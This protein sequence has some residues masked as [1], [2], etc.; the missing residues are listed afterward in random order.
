M[1]RNINMHLPYK[2]RQDIYSKYL[3][4]I[5]RDIPTNIAVGSVANEYNLKS[6][7]IK[8]CIKEGERS[9]AKLV[10]TAVKTTG[11]ITSKDCDALWTQVILARANHKCEIYGCNKTKSIQAHHIFPRTMWALR[12]EIINGIALCIGHHFLFPTSAHKDAIGFSAWV[13]TVRDIP[14]LESKKHNRSKHDYQAIYLHLKNE[15][16]KITNGNH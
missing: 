11:K 5:Q 9:K 13:K 1:V 14:Y 12:Y 16:N 2:T 3:Y 6:H 8:K 4:L 10:R 15:L 7:D